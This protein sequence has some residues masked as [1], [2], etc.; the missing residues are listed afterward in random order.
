M[1][2]VQQHNHLKKSIDFVFKDPEKI[3]K[4]KFQ[5]MKAIPFF[6]TKDPSKLK[7]SCLTNLQ[8]K[9]FLVAF[10][11]TDNESDSFHF[12]EIPLNLNDEVHTKCSKFLFRSANNDETS[13]KVLDIQFFSE[14]TLSVLLEQ[15]QENRTAVF[16][17]FPTKI[18][19]EQGQVMEVGSLCANV[20]SCDA[21]SLM[22]PSTLRPMENLV[23]STFAVSGTRKV[24]VVLSESKRRVRLFEMEVEEEEEEED[25]M[26]ATNTTKDSETS[27]RVDVS[28]STDHNDSM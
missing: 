28:T 23:A 27:Q 22:E 1:S 18:A 5:P 7:I 2:L 11:E 21:V 10:L 12:L 3:I 6:H 26:D 17:Q 13:H 8:D 9:K 24:A 15:K 19:S 20:P 25:A 16:V 4:T 14:E